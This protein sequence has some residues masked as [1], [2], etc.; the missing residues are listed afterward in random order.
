MKQAASQFG[1]LLFAVLLAV[2]PAVGAVP[3][4]SPCTS[5]P[6]CCAG[7]FPPD[8]RPVSAA[9]LQWKAA[10]CCPPTTAGDCRLGAEAVADRTLCITGTGLPG[11]GSVLPSEIRIPPF[12]RGD[13]ALR[14]PSAEHRAR[15]GAIPLYLV[16][17]ALLR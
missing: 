11:P 4:A 10:G 17:Q 2:T 12:S 13:G 16:K 6:C 8:G 7:A 3:G 9:A 5:A 1:V 14:I 15:Y